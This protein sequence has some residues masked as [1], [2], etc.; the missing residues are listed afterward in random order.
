MSQDALSKLVAYPI[1]HLSKRV[2]TLPQ[3]DEV[4]ERP[5]GTAR[6]NFRANRKHMVEGRHF[7]NV[8]RAADEIRP[9]GNNPPGRLLLLT[10]R[11]YLLLVKSFHDPLA[12]Q[13]QEA[14]I[15]GYFRAK[16]DAA[17]AQTQ[18]DPLDFFKDFATALREQE[19]L[20]S[21]EMRNVQELVLKAAYAVLLARAGPTAVAAPVHSPAIVSA[22]ELARSGLGFL[23]GQHLPEKF[24]GWETAE[25]LGRRLNKSANS[26]KCRMTTIFNEEPNIGPEREIRA[27]ALVSQAIGFDLEKLKASADPDTGLATFY[28]EDHSCVA[29][30]CQDVKGQIHWRN[31]WSPKFVAWLFPKLQA[32]YGV[33]T[34]PRTA[35][36]EFSRALANSGMK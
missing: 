21:M 1:E 7:Y 15:D 13:V 8:D 24:K 22:D 35:E 16:A 6:R 23:K 30:W 26:V 33:R 5:A 18:K 2:I 12:W 36:L 4:H 34:G 17:P 19:K 32:K 14:L 25:D 11:G 20:G 9:R 28:N 10:E 27:N 29:L 31:F 3:M